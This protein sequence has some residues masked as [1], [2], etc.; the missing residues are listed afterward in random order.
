MDSYVYMLSRETHT[1]MLAERGGMGAL[2]CQSGDGSHH[3]L[4]CVKV[5]AFTS[6]STRSLRPPGNL[7]HVQLSDLVEQPER[8]KWHRYEKSAPAVYDL[9]D[10]WILA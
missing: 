6:S 7:L 10:R 3:G 4:I 1:R 5:I 2:T 9:D 8:L